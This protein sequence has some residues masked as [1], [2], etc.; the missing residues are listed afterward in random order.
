MSVGGTGTCTLTVANAGPATASKVVAA[1]V[2]PAALS[3]TSC[4][5]GCARHG[6]VYVWTLASL[7]NGASAQ[8]SITVKA[9][10]AGTATVLAVA[11]SQSPDRNPLN[12]ISL[13]PV[14]IK[15]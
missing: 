12:N 4:S 6:N 14:S 3:E 8:F 7:G 11:A 13:A 1:I 5:S 10:R 15:K 9:S 2:L